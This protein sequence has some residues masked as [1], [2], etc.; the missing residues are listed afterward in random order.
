MSD[1]YKLLERE[2]GWRSIPYICSEGYPTVGYGF[3][4]GPKG[5]PLSNYTFVLP[6]EAGDA[7]FSAYLKEMIQ[8]MYKDPRIGPALKRVDTPRAA[9]LMSMAYQM[10]VAGLAGF[11]NTL[12][13]IAKGDYDQAAKNMLVSKWAR[14]TPERA[15]RHSEQ[16]RTGVWD[17]SYV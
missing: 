7:W 10:G 2:E 5:A 9:I 13:L 1:I 6:R 3:R 16:L 15:K 11:S 17:K 12:S 8:D 14:Q 4:I